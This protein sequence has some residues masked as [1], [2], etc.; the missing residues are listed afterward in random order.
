MATTRFNLIQW[1]DDTTT[2]DRTQFNDAF[3]SIDN[4]GA[5]YT[6]S[7]GAP[8]AASADKVGFVHFNTTDETLFY[9]DGTAWHQ[10][11]VFGNT[12]DATI[13]AITPGDSKAAGSSTELAKADHV[14]EM[15]AFGSISNLASFTSSNNGSA[16]TFARSDHTH[17][18][19]NGTITNAMLAGSIT[20][21]KIAAGTIEGSNILST[22]TITAD[23]YLVGG[24]DGITNVTGS[25]GNVQT[26]GSGA[27]GYEG[28]SID[29]HTVFMAQSSTGTY[30]LYDDQNDQ[31]SIAATRNGAT[32]LYY[33]GSSKLA[34]ASGGVSVTGT[35]TATTFSGA[36]SGNA[37]TATSATSATTA[38]N[39]DAAANNSNNESTY[40]A[41]VD[42]ATGAQRIE[43]DTGLRYNPSSNT[44]TAT[45]FSGNATSATNASTLDGV[46]STE[47][48]RS[49]QNDTASGRLTFTGGG[50][51]AGNTTLNILDTASTATAGIS[52][53]Y[54][55]A[56]AFNHGVFRMS[57]A[58]IHRYV[59]L[60]EDNASLADIQVQAVYYN[61]GSFGTSDLNLKTKVGD[62]PGLD[63]VDTLM[64][65]TGRWNAD[66]DEKNQFFLGAQEVEESLS[67]AGLDPEDYGIVGF[68]TETGA[69]A[70]DY[71]QLIPVLIQAV[72]DLKGR[73]EAVEAGS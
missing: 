61:G 45:T 26:V 25:Y 70:M 51:T 49:N 73:L 35:V 59:F 7:T 65:F 48:L 54:T 24:D 66:E 20:G 14:H 16:A 1:V 72:K 36:L 12:T 17:G 60:Q 55:H 64:P 19:P 10:I 67:A 38:T 44:L 63:F 40:I 46:D 39:V 31:W 28:Y 52:F 6:Q 23:T 21:S 53:R 47:F 58:N 15:P 8:A 33:N 50:G 22:T 37:T 41:F 2:V 27:G 3:A 68:N 11:N 43:T 13:S 71:V 42:G 29:G 56:S 4:L 32:N 30:G 9:C 18:I 34:T 5:G 62:S 69:M 57:N